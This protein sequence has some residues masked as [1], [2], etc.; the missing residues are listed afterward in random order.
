MT[1]RTTR[2]KV[3]PIADSVVGV[4]L[5]ATIRRVVT[6]TGVH[7]ASVALP[8]LFEAVGRPRAGRRIADR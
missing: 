5:N 3:K 2:L 8:R 1:R 4:Y 6:I 7:L